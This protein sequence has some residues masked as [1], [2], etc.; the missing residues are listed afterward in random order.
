LLELLNEWCAEDGAPVTDEALSRWLA[1]EH[2]GKTARLARALRDRVP[3]SGYGRL[4]AL[5]ALSG[6]IERAERWAASSAPPN[7]RMD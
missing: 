7:G 2:S 1:P 3:A 6:R 5:R 4:A